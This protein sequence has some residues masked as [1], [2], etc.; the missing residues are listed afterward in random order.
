MTLA[1]TFRT[2]LPVH[3]QSNGAGAIGEN[4]PRE[5]IYLLPHRTPGPRRAIL[6]SAATPRPVP[7]VFGFCQ[8]NRDGTLRAEYDA[9]ELT[10]ALA[11]W[12]AEFGV[13]SDAA[14]VVAEV[15]GACHVD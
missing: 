15:F 5:R 3:K 11:V 13:K 9:D 12:A 14:S 4:L 2:S 6:W 10:R 7:V 1:D 8:T